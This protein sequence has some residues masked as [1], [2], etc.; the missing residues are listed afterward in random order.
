MPSSTRPVSRRGSVRTADTSTPSRGQRLAHEAAHV[1]VA[2]AGQH[3]DLEAEAG[4]PDG[5]VA[6]RAAEVLGEMLRVL[7]ARAALEAVEIDRGAAEADEVDVA[8]HRAHAR[9]LPSAA[10][11][12]GGSQI[13]APGFIVHAC[14]AVN[15]GTS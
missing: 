1:L 11:R 5:D 3:R 14:S 12:G 9:G 13:F 4:Q 10:G 7:E 15:S 8:R 2:D 6:G